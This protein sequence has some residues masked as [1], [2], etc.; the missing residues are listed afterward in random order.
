MI[1]LSGLSAAALRA[2]FNDMAAAVIVVDERGRCVEANPAACSLLGYRYGHLLELHLAALT[3]ASGERIEEI[4]RRLDD[5]PLRIETE[6]R[7]RD[8][9]S[10]E[11]EVALS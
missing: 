5:Q 10:V 1:S 3:F 6:L 8:G 7:R 2:V 4:R 11:V 9:T